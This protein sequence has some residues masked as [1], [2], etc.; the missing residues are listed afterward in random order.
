MVGVLLPLIFY[1]MHLI[2]NVEDESE[3]TYYR[4]T[5]NDNNYLTDG[6]PNYIHDRNCC[7]ACNGTTDEGDIY[8]KKIMLY[9]FKDIERTTI[10]K[11]KYVL[12]AYICDFDIESKTFSKRDGWVDEYTLNGYRNCLEF[13]KVHLI[14][15][16]G[17]D[18]YI[19]EDDFLNITC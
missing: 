7:G 15:A 13:R 14:N 17:R 3:T 16:P 6:I 19:R 2:N 9:E 18:Y 12:A 1:S 11:T 10:T 4:D 5:A 8:M